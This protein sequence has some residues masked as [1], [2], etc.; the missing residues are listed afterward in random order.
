MSPLRSLAISV[1]T[2]VVGLACADF[3]Y[4]RY[5]S[6]RYIPEQR[7]R[8]A[9]AEGDG[10]VLTVGDSRMVAGIDHA[11]LERAFEA[12]GTPVC[13]AS[14]AIGALKLSG[15]VIVLRRYLELRRPKMVVFGVSEGSLLPDAE[16]EDPSAMVGNRAVELAW[17]NGEERSALYPSFELESLDAQFRHRVR[18][19]TALGSFASLAWARLKTMEDG[20]VRLGPAG[21]SNQFGLLSDMQ[22]LGGSF[23]REALDKL[24]RWDGRFPRSFW[25]DRARE[26]ARARGARVVVVA[27]PMPS[28]YRRAVNETPAARRF[29]RWLEQR[30]R[31]AGERYVDLSA[32]VSDDQFH[33]G[34]HLAAPGAATFST[35]LAAALSDSGSAAP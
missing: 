19:A 13:T 28:A 2:F 29:H 4:G 23:Q 1:L 3:G 18:S 35:R 22:A 31:D 8:A 7:F 15:Q 26:L 24:A 12:S 21:P 14:I 30:E 32:A 20:L 27:V 16:R 9:V 10:C 17:S 5:A 34:I 33:D 6:L 11:T 25:L